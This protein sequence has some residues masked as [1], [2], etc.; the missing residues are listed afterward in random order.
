M[1]TCPKCERIFE[2]AGQPHSC[3]KVPLERHFR[4]KDLAKEL[5]EFLVKEIEAKIGECKII[6]I[7]CCIHLYG[8][9]DFLAALPKRDRLEIRFAMPQELDSPRLKQS[10]PL[11]AK[12]FKERLD[13]LTAGEVD[14]QLIEWLDTAYHLKDN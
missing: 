10:V 14:G 7:P 9:Y 2:K 8:T 5:F 4:N 13:L 1:W 11:S 12:T 3:H 6:S